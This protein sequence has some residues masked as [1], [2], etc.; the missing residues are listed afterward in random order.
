MFRPI[1]MFSVHLRE[2]WANQLFFTRQ[3]IYCWI[4]CKKVDDISQKPFSFC[5]FS[6]FSFSRFFHFDKFRVWQSFYLLFMCISHHTNFFVSAI[7]SFLSST[8]SLCEN[9][10]TVAAVAVW[11]YYNEIKINTFFYRTCLKL[12]ECNMMQKCEV[13]QRWLNT[14]LL[15]VDIKLFD[16]CLHI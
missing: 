6:T 16:T 1:T 10:H 5:T 14:Q 11:S 7:L 15:R 3:F 9:E 4:S 13:E 12:I 2:I 8:S